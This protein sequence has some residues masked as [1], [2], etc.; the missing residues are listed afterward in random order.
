[1]TGTHSA[2]D[3]VVCNPLRTPIGK[4]GGVLK[5]V[6]A[7][8]L[9]T[10]LTRELLAANEPLRAAV[11]EV[12]LGQAWPTAE[13]PAIGRVVA[14]DAGLP[15]EV[16]GYQVDRRCGSGLQAIID[17]AMHVRSGFSQVVVAGGAENM[18]R[19]PFYVDGARF[20]RPMGAMTLE[21]SLS[22]GR[23]TAGG[24]AY[25]IAGGMI[26]TA[27]TLRRDHGISRAAQDEYAL[28][29]QT[30]AAHAQAQ[31]WFDD[32]I[33]GVRVAG[34]RSGDTVVTVD[35]QPRPSTTLED[36][37]RLRPVMQSA[38]PD[39]TVT[40]GNSSSQNDAAALCVVTTRAAADRL[41]LDPVVTVVA[42]SHAGVDP[43]CMGL[44]PVPATERALARAGWS[45]SSI[46]HLE[47]NEAF[48]AQVLAVLQRWDLG[49]DDLAR[50]NPLGSGIS[51]GHP[52]GA[53]GARL[54][55]S[56]AR[57]LRRTGGGRLLVT[58]CVGGGQGLAALFEAA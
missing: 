25:P 28:R 54:V 43:R 55:V 29:S 39:A 51:L 23:V 30:R 20:R 12:V 31:G 2:D 14:L 49:G 36:L 8:E 52:V 41:G 10:L 15:I 53:T 11:D 26:E 1:M 3:V 9:A 44:G 18:S 21:D 47:L 32:E 27:E 17:A 57:Y 56:G 5:D 58:M 4:F 33:V 46:D 19:A 38:D 45:L 34:G 35:E 50:V 13:A 24:N 7:A 22:R 40:A 37:A 48:A 6:P 42:A 16:S